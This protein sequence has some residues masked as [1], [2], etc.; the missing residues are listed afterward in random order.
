MNRKSAPE[1]GMKLPSIESN[2]FFNK[3]PQNNHLNKFREYIN[4]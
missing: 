1:L 3:I 2:K 4:K